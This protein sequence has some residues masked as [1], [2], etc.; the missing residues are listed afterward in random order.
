MLVLNAVSPSKPSSTTATVKVAGVPF[1]SDTLILQ[2]AFGLNSLA[3][4]TSGFKCVA[5]S[6]TITGMIP[7]KRIGKL[8]EVCVYACTKLICT[9]TF[10]AIVLSVLNL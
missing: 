9:Y 2:G 3:A 6:S 7:Y 10:G 4:F 1:F 5:A 8:F